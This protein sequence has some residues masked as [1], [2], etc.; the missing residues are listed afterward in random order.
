[1]PTNGQ[2]AV[3]MRNFAREGKLALVDKKGR[4]GLNKE[5]L[6]AEKSKDKDKAKKGKGKGKAK[7]EDESMHDADGSDEEESLEPI[8]SQ[9]LPAIGTT[10][11]V[12]PVTLLEQWATEIETH[13]GGAL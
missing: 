1:M 2:L 13:T 8:T 5:D 11:I 6:A 9:R 3:M 4:Y 12:V 7:E 10:L